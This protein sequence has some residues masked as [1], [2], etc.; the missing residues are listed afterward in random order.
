M[1]TPSAVQ[2]VT[3]CQM[4]VMFGLVS[5]LAGGQRGSRFAGGTCLVGDDSNLVGNPLLNWQPMDLTTQ[6]YGT[7]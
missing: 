1:L 6:L 5:S 2:T 4:I 7:G 3:V